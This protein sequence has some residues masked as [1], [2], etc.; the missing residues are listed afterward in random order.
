MRTS[1][2]LIVSAALIALASCTAPADSTTRTQPVVGKTVT[3]TQYSVGD[4]Y[5]NT[6]YV[7]ASWAPDRQRILVSSNLSGIWNAYA[8]P[9]GGGTH[10]RLHQ[11]PATAA[12]SAISRPSLANLAAPAENR[13]TQ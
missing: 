13:L 4:F 8:V 12:T 3:P 10:R 1:T 6:E 5:K 7:G 2:D 11:G 9:T